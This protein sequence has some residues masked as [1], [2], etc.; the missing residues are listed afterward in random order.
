MDVFLEYCRQAL[1]VESKPDLSQHLDAL[2]NSDFERLFQDP[3]CQILCGKA[4]DPI[5][6]NVDLDDFPVWTDYISHRLKLLIRNENAT[7]GKP[8][9]K[10]AF[11]ILLGIAGV[12]AFSQSNVTGPPLS[13]R[14]RELLLPE[15]SSESSIAGQLTQSLIADGISPYR[16][17]PNLELFCLSKAIFYS[18]EIELATPLASWMRLR[19]AF[20]HQR[21]LSEISPTLQSDIF[22]VVAVVQLLVI[23]SQSCPANLRA[24][25]LLEKAMVYLHHGQDAEARQFLT[26]A[27][28]V[29]GFEYALTGILGKKTKYQSKDTSQLLVLARSSGDVEATLETATE[30]NSSGGQK[31]LPANL[32]LND[33]TLLESISFAKAEV[34]DENSLPPSLMTMDPENQPQLHPLDSIILLSTAAAITNTSPAD[35]ITREETLPYATRVLD[36]AD[37]NWQVYTQALLV[38]SRIEGYRSRTVERSLLQLQALV[39]QV[40]VDL[41][42]SASDPDTQQ[43]TFLP[44][45]SKNDSAPA[46]RRLQYIFQLNA[47]TRWELE[48]ELAARWVSLGGLASALEIYERLEMWAEVALCL[49]GTDKEERARRVIRKQLFHSVY[50]KDDDSEQWMGGER[51]PL[52]TD[53]PRLY[54]ILG[55]LDRSLKM[56]EKAWEVS[57]ARYG[58][59]QLA[60]G[61]YWYGR[62]DYA[63]ASV[64]YST[65]LKI[66]Q[67]DHGTWFTLG[68]CFLELGQYSRAAEVFSRAVQI[69]DSDAESWSNLAVALLHSTPEGPGREPV[70]DGGSAESTEDKDSTTDGQCGN[71]DRQTHR[72]QALTALKQAAKLKRDDYRIWENILTVA[73]SLAPAAFSDIVV[74]QQRIVD[75]RGTTDGENCIDTNILDALVRY[76]TG[77]APKDASDSAP[78]A[79]NPGL[80]R[81]ACQLVDGSV[82]PLI[83]TSSQLWYIVASLEV[84]RGNPRAALDAEE[85]AWRA[86]S[87]P[88][89][90]ET[91]TE[92]QWKAV[93]GA[94]L[95]LADNYQQ[96]G[97]QSGTET[98]ELASKDWKFK[99]RSAVRGILGRGKSSWEGTQGWTTLNDALSGLRTQ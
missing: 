69:D 16:L 53:A 92:E 89:G 6:D 12:L 31:D 20:L 56:Y 95:R 83:T 32:D 34:Q 45:P 70:Q 71:D 63:R 27:T 26:E 81:M 40:I 98:E 97:S 29:R 46:D 18:P 47:P 35:G 75:L 28:K 78:D 77:S 66:K 51:D 55:D 61:R 84:W 52:P 48:A 59:A 99:A 30:Q 80:V 17:V 87:S 8:S 86:L 91:G 49:A 96:L 24:C 50:G 79:A 94:T 65:A 1:P 25:F 67:L 23:D 38:R 36:G 42:D 10:L 62:K 33:D 54:C 88:T 11:F 9:P 74:A 64:A 5:L 58:R 21:L 13:F 57:N 90:W 22:R 43:T 19:T 60:I 7:D 4:N 41:K 76:I 73:A 72:R 39:D 82:V 93:V 85:K 3:L 37:T 44:R 15:T 68:C 2:Q 14:P